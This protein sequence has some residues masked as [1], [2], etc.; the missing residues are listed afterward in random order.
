MKKSIKGKKMKFNKIKN[1][2]NYK[3]IHKNLKNI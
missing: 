3:K 2:K 1:N